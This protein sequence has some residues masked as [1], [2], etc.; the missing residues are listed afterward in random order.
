M[1]YDFFL[2]W[3]NGIQYTEEIISSIRNEN[4]FIIT[5][6]LRYK[7]KFPMRMRTFVNKV[8]EPDP[9][10]FSHLRK[11]TKY[12]LKSPRICIFV[13]V[14]NMKPNE[15]YFGEGNF[16]ILQCKQVKNL[17]EKIRNNFNPRF[18]NPKTQILP[19]NEGVSHNH[20]IH[21][22]D[23]EKQVEHLLELFGLPNLDYFKR[24]NN[25][26]FE[27]PWHLNVS[28]FKIQN[29]KL[30]SLSVRLLKRGIVK[31][32]DSPHY[33][34]ILGNKQPYIDYF[35]NNFYFGTGP[36]EDHFPQK[37]DY[38]INSFRLNY[39]EINGKKCKIIIDN[40]DVILDGVHRAAICL[41]LGIEEISCIQ[42]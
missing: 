37:F 16:K 10:P 12:L 33:Q 29:R 3:G 26:E 5:A 6:I 19:L 14:K 11:K 34:Y 31:V 38:L 27:I 41:N 15:M 20:C 28:Q 30:D 18:K 42:I 4:N 9:T 1:R 17:K 32:S 2:I 8:Y 24:Y 23:N 21:A 7:V 40:N 13:L 22:S 25:N 36:F 35:Y 39:T